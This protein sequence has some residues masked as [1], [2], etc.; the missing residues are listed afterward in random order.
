MPGT[1]VKFGQ[2]TF[3]LCSEIENVTFGSDWTQIDLA[4]FR[5]AGKIKEI[6][7]PAK[8]SRIYNINSLKGLTRVTVDDNNSQYCSIDGI[9]YTKD[10]KVLLACPLAYGEQSRLRTMQQP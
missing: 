7:I 8:V 6:S 9:I 1:Q 10:A 2:G 3:F 5:W 4:G